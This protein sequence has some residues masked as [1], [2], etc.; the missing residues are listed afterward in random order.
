MGSI[1]SVVCVF[2]FEVYLYSWTGVELCSHVRYI[3][4]CGR[5]EIN[6]T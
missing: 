1:M 5:A 3:L 6:L 4:W 2:L